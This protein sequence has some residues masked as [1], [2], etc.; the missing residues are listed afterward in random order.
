M[1]VSGNQDS[2]FKQ[3][4][5]KVM[6]I[7]CPSGFLSCLM[8]TTEENSGNSQVLVYHGRFKLDQRQ[9]EFLSLVKIIPMSCSH[10]R[11]IPVTC[12]VIGN[13]ATE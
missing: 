11:P 12:V 9:T 8:L 2:H 4:F 13:E 5:N 7:Y 1:A 6:I 3:F 10:V